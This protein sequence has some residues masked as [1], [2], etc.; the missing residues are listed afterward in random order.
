MQHFS[1][2]GIRCLPYRDPPCPKAL[3]ARQPRLLR[4]PPSGGGTLVLR[5]ASGDVA[6]P[7]EALDSARMGGRTGSA[8]VRQLTDRTAPPDC[9][10]A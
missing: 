4:L 2:Q 1:S 5:G 6:N 9:G 8:R 3:P 7:P 10:E